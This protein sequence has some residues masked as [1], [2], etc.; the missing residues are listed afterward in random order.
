MEL[1]IQLDVSRVYQGKQPPFLVSN[2]SLKDQWAPAAFVFANLLWSVPL[3]SAP[4]D[5]NLGQLGPAFPGRS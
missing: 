1:W 5:L 2:T 3:D 4:L